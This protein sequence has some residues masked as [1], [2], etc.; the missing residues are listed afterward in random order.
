M[1]EAY[2]VVAANTSVLFALAMMAR[3][4]EK[5]VVKTM[6]KASLFRGLLKK[7]NTSID[8]VGNNDERT[9]LMALATA[10]KTASS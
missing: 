8:V 1:K 7:Y 3:V 4:N 9:V 5:I 6:M 10:A 2:A